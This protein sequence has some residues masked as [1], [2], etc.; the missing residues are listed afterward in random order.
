[1]KRRRTEDVLQAAGDQEAPPPR[2]EFVRDL[3]TRFGATRVV[4]VSATRRPV[5][6]AIAGVAAAAVVA[7]GFLL[8]GADHDD[9]GVATL[10]TLATTTTAQP[11]P[12][13]TIAIPGTTTSSQ[14]SAPT[15]V[16]HPSTTT[17]TAVP[18]TTS[19]STIATTST[20]VPPADLGLRCATRADT[21]AV[22]CEWSASSDAS[23]DHFRLWKHTGDGPDEELYSGTALRFEDHELSGARKY[24]EVTA[25]A[26]DG[27][28]LG[29]GEVL[30]T[31]C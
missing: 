4:T 19:T 15:T 24:Y 10:P 22:I 26:A 13:T 29:Y 8:A 31:C 17:T 28:I 7:G 1:M 23:F 6:W 3:E 18:T 12:T 11:A 2:P 20:S 30:V 16:P 25:V 5:G 27:R 14:P 21:N 9:Q